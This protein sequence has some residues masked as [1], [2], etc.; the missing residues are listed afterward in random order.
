MSYARAWTGLTKQTYKRGN[1]EDLTSSDRVDPLTID[2]EKRDVFP[3]TDLKGGYIGDGFPLC[4][5]LPP[6][7]HLHKVCSEE[8]S[9]LYIT[10]YFLIYVTNHFIYFTLNYRGPHTWSLAA[11][12]SQN[13][14]GRTHLGETLMCRG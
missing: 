11:T 1:T 2:R 3:K 8:N 13:S 5:D 9:I 6:R 7:M 10:C 14:N 4:A 12:A